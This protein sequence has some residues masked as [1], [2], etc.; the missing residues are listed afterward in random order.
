MLTRK[1]FFI[2]TGSAGLIIVAAIAWILVSP[3]FIDEIVEEAF[4]IPTPR[5]LAEMSAENKAAIRDDVMA[6]A[7]KMPP[8]EMV[9]P[10]PDQT[11]QTAQT[12]A[13]VQGQFRDA[14]SRHKGSGDASLLRLGDSKHLLRL[15]KFRVTN[16]PDLRVILSSHQNPTNSDE[17]HQ[18]FVDLGALKGNVGSQNYALPNTIDP[19]AIHSVLIYCRAFGVIFSVASLQ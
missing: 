11:A 18:G 15:D 6:A 5:V 19:T 2:V 14:D 8:K 7:S 16:G 13:V 10:M 12:A 17:A 1:K 3:L 9:E 4:P